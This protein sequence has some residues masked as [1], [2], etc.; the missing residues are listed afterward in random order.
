ME[1]LSGFGVETFKTLVWVAAVIVGGL[2]VF[3]GPVTFS[4]ED[5]RQGY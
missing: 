2:F 1:L 5:R 3:G 4:S